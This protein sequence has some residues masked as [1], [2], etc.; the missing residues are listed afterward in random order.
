MSF[1]L[2]PRQVSCTA[3][4]SQTAAASCLSHVVHPSHGTGYLG[5][6]ATS[7]IVSMLANLAGFTEIEGGVG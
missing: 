3:L 4:A 1:P 2:W 6:V 7:S 5:L